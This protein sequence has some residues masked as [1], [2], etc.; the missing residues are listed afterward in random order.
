MAIGRQAFPWLQ[1][2]R[3]LL[4]QGRLWTRDLTFNLCR[5]MRPSVRSYSNDAP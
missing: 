4:G 3:Q 2:P 5:Q 1:A